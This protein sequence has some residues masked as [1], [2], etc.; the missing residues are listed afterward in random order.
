MTVGLGLFI[1]I[2]ALFLSNTWCIIV[3]HL[4]YL[5]FSRCGVLLTTYFILVVEYQMQNV[6]KHTQ[7]H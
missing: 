5:Y 6:I 1:I 7:S 2:S 3:R 4:L